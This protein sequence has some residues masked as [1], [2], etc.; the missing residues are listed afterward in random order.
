MATTEETNE[1]LVRNQGLADGVA[2]GSWVVDGNTSDNECASILRMMDECAWDGP[3]LRLGEW[4]DD[5]T[6]GDILDAA[7]VPGTVDDDYEDDL[8]CVYSDAWYEGMQN[9]VER[10]CRARL[11]TPQEPQ[12]AETNRE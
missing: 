7:G 10:T 8:F 9:E 2:A 12:R 3:E 4:A 11:A 5:P 1:L 6:F